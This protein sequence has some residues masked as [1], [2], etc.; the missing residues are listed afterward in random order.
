MVTPLNDGY[1]HMTCGMSLNPMAVPAK[2]ARIYDDRIELS[3]FSTRLY[4]G[5]QKH[6]LVALTLQMLSILPSVDLFFG[7]GH[8]IRFPEVFAAGTDMTG[9]F[10]MPLHADVPRLCR[11]TPAP[12]MV[13]AVMPITTAERD[14]LSLRPTSWLS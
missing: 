3:A 5:D 6:D 2:E 1:V 10:F 4:E 13:L 8:A 9:I 7:A 11:C 12:K 14:F